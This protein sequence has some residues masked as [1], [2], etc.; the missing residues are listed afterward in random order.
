MTRKNQGYV[1]ELY[2]YTRNIILFNLEDF[3]V[4]GMVDIKGIV[5]RVYFYGRKIGF[6]KPPDD[7]INDV[8]GILR[9]LLGVTRK[10]GQNYSDITF[11]DVRKY[12]QELEKGR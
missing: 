9:G 8:T 10:A 1:Q 5:K 4:N 2:D 12:L 11:F 3:V 6:T 7:L